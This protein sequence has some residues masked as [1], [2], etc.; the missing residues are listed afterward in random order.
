MTAYRCC[1][2]LLLTPFFMTAAEQVSVPAA[3]AK[4][5][6]TSQYVL[7][8]D[9]QIKVW[10]LGM[11]EI[12]DKPVR[13]D[14]SGDIDL[15]IIGKIHAG[16]LTAEQLT[17]RLV[18]RFAS[19]VRA[20]KVSIEIVEFG[21]Q[22]ISVLGAVNRPGIVQL[23][24][25]KTLSEV[26]SMVEG[27]SQSAGPHINI[28]RRLQAGPIPLSNAKTDPSGNFSVAE[29]QVRNLLTGANP[30]ENIL[31]C[32]H[33]V[34]TVPAAEMVFVMGEVRKPGPVALNDREGISA[35]QAVSMAEGFGPAPAPQ[36]AKI[37][38][39][40]PGTQAR[41]EIPVD[42]RKVLAGKAEDIGLRANDILVVPP[43]GSKKAAVRVLEAAVQTVTGVIIWRRP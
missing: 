16:G 24:G 37:V 43:S 29:V 17:T 13:I 33:D 7:G 25:R 20:P 3:P 15:P 35:L 4:L 5:E 6:A 18:G 9:D 34:I 14:P 12:S 42:L 19:E 27:L 11:E 23:H 41:Q 32:P 39:I 22:P 28:S 2:L 38:R 21:S 36:A 30:A 40:V 26:L 8:P 31:I 1:F 10:S